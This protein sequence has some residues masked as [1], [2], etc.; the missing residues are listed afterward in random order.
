MLIFG[1]D[2]QL[3]YI[4]PMDT[5]SRHPSFSPLH[6]TDFVMHLPF[7]Y[8]QAFFSFLVGS[9]DSAEDRTLA[10]RSGDSGFE[11]SWRGIE[12]LTLFPRSAKAILGTRNVSLEIKSIVLILITSPTELSINVICVCMYALTQEHVFRLSVCLFVGLP[13]CLFMFIPN[14]QSVCCLSLGRSVCP[15]A[16]LYVCLLPACLSAILSLCLSAA[17]V[18]VCCL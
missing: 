18:S 3:H 1:L 4:C 7:R 15:S 17:C 13:A 10:G 8:F 14:C 2:T 16:S 5:Q 11:L 12:N 9:L 6:A